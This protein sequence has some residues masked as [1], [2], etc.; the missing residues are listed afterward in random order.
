MRILRWICL[1]TAQAVVTI[2]QAQN[3]QSMTL[4]DTPDNY[5]GTNGPVYRI[6]A[7]VRAN[8]GD[9]IAICDKRFSGNDIGVKPLKPEGSYDIDIVA[10]I[11]KSNSSTWSEELTLL[12]GTGNI[13]R[14]D[15]AYGDACAVVDRESG[16]VLV[17]A[18]AGH[19]GFG[20]SSYKNPLRMIRIYG[21]LKD[22]KWTWSKPKEFTSKIY[23]NAL[24]K[25][26]AGTFFSSGRMC[27]SST[28]K[29]GSHYRIY[30]ALPTRLDGQWELKSFKTVVVYSDDF[31]KTWH[32]LGGSEARP[33][34]AFG[35]EAKVEE[36]PNGHVLLSNRAPAGRIFSVFKYS[37]KKT[38]QE[39]QWS[40][41]TVCIKTFT[42][43]N[44]QHED[45]GCNGEL[46]LVPVKRTA[47][48]KQMH[49]LLQSI[50]LG[51]PTI[52]TRS[53]VGIYYKVLASPT[54][55]DNTAAFATG[56]N[57][58]EV[59]SLRSAYSTMV[60]NHRDGVDFL[61]ENN[62]DNYNGINENGYG[63]DIDYTSIS[64]E[65][66]TNGK[67]VFDLQSNSIR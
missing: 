29:V 65:A 21:T 31:G 50:P 61:Y 38:Y 6:P 24:Q 59:T 63:Y 8:N 17:I 67:Y 40:K 57:P 4:F 54:D 19:T 34:D 45:H 25:K 2:C 35:N 60:L 49:L 28:I 44:K 9:V 26:I 46:L 18:G 56:W 3:P 20:L 13:K 1:I 42:R 55:Y 30:A 53:H 37:D 10:K 48:G 12:D 41:D 7:I 51:S 58:Y 47:D 36:L 16:K 62:T 22:N 39:G 52:T 43:Q 32:A 15:C 5:D 33:I 11:K 27:Q 66:I 14:K 23:T 64:I